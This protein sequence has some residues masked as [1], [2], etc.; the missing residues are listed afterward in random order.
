MKAVL[1]IF[2]FSSACACLLLIAPRARASKAKAD[3]AIQAIKQA[4]DPSAA[5]TAFANGSFFR[6]HHD[7]DRAHHNLDRFRIRPPERER[8]VFHLNNPVVWHHD[9]REGL[10]FSVPLLVRI[11]RWLNGIKLPD[12]LSVRA[13]ADPVPTDL[14]R[15]EVRLYRVGWVRAMVAVLASILDCRFP[16][17]SEER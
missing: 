6:H 8:E 4:S 13:S 16:S 11:N 3:A 5:V 14:L 10:T 7:F 1:R 15:R 9:F 12:P 2:F 17:L